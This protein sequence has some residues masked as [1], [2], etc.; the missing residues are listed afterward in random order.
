MTANQLTKKILN[1]LFEEHGCFVWRE[2]T[3]GIPTTGGG[4]RPASMK[5]KPDIMGMTS[6]GQFIGVEVKIGKDRLSL[7]QKGFIKNAAHCGVKIFI[8][9]DFDEFKH[10]FDKELKH[11]PR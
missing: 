10:T 3:V 11:P 7:E 8:A 9:K 6:E 4:L 5:G 1:Y 2:D